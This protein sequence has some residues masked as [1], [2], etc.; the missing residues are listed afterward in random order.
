M[1]SKR[2]ENT[3]RVGAKGGSGQLPRPV[4][5][6]VDAAGAF[7]EHWGFKRVQGEIWAL[8]YLADRPLMATEV[9]QALGVSKALVSLAMSELL[10]YRVLLLA[11]GGD[12]RSQRLVANE[13]LG[14]AIAAVLRLRETR[15]LDDAR[16]S[17][18]ALRSMSPDARGAIGVDPKRV[19]AAEQFIQ[20]AR[21]ALDLL[22]VWMNGA[23]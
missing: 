13:N 12:G 11:E 14:E 6:F 2:Y 16:A 23:A 20:E 22:V 19:A 15:L 9:A 3:R 21:R 8:V 17:V 4:R 18:V 5:A 10:E 1:T 7:I